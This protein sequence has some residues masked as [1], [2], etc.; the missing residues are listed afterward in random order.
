MI[1]ITTSMVRKSTS[2]FLANCLI[3]GVVSLKTALPGSENIIIQFLKKF[4]G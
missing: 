4:W 1:I 2:H 3:N